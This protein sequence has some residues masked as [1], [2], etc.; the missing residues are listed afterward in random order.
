MVRMGWVPI[1]GS[2]SEGKYLPWKKISDARQ[3]VD[4]S[5]LVQME[6]VGGDLGRNCPLSAHHYTS[7]PTQWCSQSKQNST[8]I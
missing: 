2:V 7:S 8:N 5:D 6:T 3:M 4:E 1:T